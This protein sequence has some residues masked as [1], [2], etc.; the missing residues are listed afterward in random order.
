MYSIYLYIF[1]L[2]NILSPFDSPMTYVHIFAPLVYRVHSSLVADCIQPARH[3]VGPPVRTPV[4]PPVRLPGEHKKRNSQARRIYIKLLH[5][6]KSIDSQ[7]V[8]WFRCCVGMFLKF[9]LFSLERIW[10]VMTMLR[11]A[12]RFSKSQ[13]HTS[14]PGARAH[15]LKV[16]ICDPASTLTLCV[17]RSCHLQDK[18]TR[19]IAQA[20]TKCASMLAQRASAAEGRTQAVQ[21]PAIHLANLAPLEVPCPVPVPALVFIRPVPVPVPQ[22]YLNGRREQNQGRN[23]QRTATHVAIHVE[24]LICASNMCDM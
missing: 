6:Q 22:R 5:V 1:I 4:C 17:I 18:I 2:I 16:Q 15:T 9:A 7:S 20:F 23:W 10:L 11:S 12:L 8:A 3:P 14:V 13:S 21:P 24:E 19:R